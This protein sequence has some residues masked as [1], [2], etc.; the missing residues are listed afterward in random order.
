MIAVAVGVV[1]AF[2]RSFKEL[3]SKYECRVV[4]LSESD[5]MI[6]THNNKELLNI[7]ASVL[8]LK[9]PLFFGSVGSLTNAYALGSINNLLAIDMTDV[10]M[11]DLSGAYALD[12]IIKDARSRDIEVFVANAQ[13]DVKSVLENVNVIRDIGESY[14]SDSKNIVVSDI[15]ESNNI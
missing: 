10:S 3:R 14:Y 2:I 6:D 1:F 8:E 15:L 12:D 11:I 7:S 4:S 13:D 5:L 9:G